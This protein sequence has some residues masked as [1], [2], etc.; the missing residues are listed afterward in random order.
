VT[1][2]AVSPRGR[3]LKVILGIAVSAVLL[4]YLFWEVDLHEIGARLANTLWGFLALSV[5]LNL[6]SLWLRAWRWYYLFPPGSRPR[7][8]FNALMI[9]YMANNLLP[10]R[11]GEVI[12]AY[13][14]SRRGQR[15]WTVVATIV[16]ERALDGL[17]IGLIIA[18]LFLVIPMPPQFRWPAIVFLTVDVIAMVVLAVIALAPGACG[19]VIRGILHRW[20][21]AE[22]RAM[23]VLGTMTEGLKGLR[24][25]HHFLPIVLSSAAIWLSFALSIWAGLHA[26]HLDLPLTASWTVLAFLGLGVS[27]PSSP[28]YV[29]VVQAATVLALALFSVPRTE[30][31]SFSILIHAS[32][33]LP[34]TAYGLVLLVVEHVSLSEATQVTRAAVVPSER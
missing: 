3:A 24:A 14:A 2:P 6:V 19:A 29:G 25:G 23:D 16:V 21:W 4:V 26:A 20:Q 7:H 11:A 27:L 5:A 8:L 9:G 32:Q 31:L 15:F 10:L 18:G 28:G 22:R 13:V 12:R 1:A 34:V 33:L 30:A 17:A